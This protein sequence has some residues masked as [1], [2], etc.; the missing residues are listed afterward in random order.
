MEIRT[1]IYKIN[2]INNKV[3]TEGSLFLDIETTGLSRSRSIIYM[4]GCAVYSENQ[5]KVIQWFNDDAV[6][7]ETILRDFLHFLEAHQKECNC[8]QSICI[9]TY[10]GDSFDLPF[11][12][13]HLEYNELDASALEQYI[14]MDLYRQFKPMQ[15]AFGL[16]SCKQ[17]DW[18]NLLSHRRDDK[19]SGKELI[20]IYQTYLKEKNE[21]QKEI[22]YLHNKDDLI[23]MSQ[24]YLLMLYCQPSL[25]RIES[26]L[27]EN[28]ALTIVCKPEAK[29]PISLEIFK[30]LESYTWGLTIT[31]D[32]IRFQLPYYNG[33]LKHFYEDYKNYYY[34]PE[35]DQAIHKS[36]GQY[37]DPAHRMK[38]NASNCYVHADGIF[39]PLPA[40]K[41]NASYSAMEKIAI[42]KTD[43][44][45]KHS[46]IEMDD[47][48]KKEDDNFV[49]LP[50]YLSLIYD[51]LLK[52]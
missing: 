35:E 33:R 23:G 30:D 25:G 19:Y 18:E 11:L 21:Q 27:P 6:S 13:K 16:S 51:Y 40:Q 47:L 4:I 32:L 5:L 39:F 9:Y 15:T 12:R 28:D 1:N 50:D 26:I 38:A 36:I 45:E 42:Y 52:Q 17:K 31:N 14:I 10:N 2:Q 37:V 43:Y 29:Y 44:L 8:S 46:Y 48:L 22:L 24:I 34:L 7:E 41:K 3:Y 20:K 49:Y